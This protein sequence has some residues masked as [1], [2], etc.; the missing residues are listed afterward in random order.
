[1]KRA[2]VGLVEQVEVDSVLKES[3]Q[4]KPEPG[5]RIMRQVDIRFVAGGPI[6]FKMFVCWD[7]KLGMWHIFV[8]GAKETVFENGEPN[9]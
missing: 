7:W 8:E 2:V 9:W 6:E 5:E 4:Q 3:L 1:M